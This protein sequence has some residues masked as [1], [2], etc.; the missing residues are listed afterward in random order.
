M[1][2]LM[3]GITEDNIRMR[4]LNLEI[5]ETGFNQCLDQNMIKVGLNNVQTIIK[6]CSMGQK[7]LTV[8][9]VKLQTSRFPCKCKG[10]SNNQYTMQPM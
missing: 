6:H 7:F 1:I 5:E 4:G 9:G 8:R 10:E 2:Y 3:L